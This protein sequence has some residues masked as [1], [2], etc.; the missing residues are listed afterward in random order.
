LPSG[1]LFEIGL[2]HDFVVEA[3]SMNCGIS[4]SGLNAQS[5]CLYFSSNN[6]VQVGGLSSGSSN[7]PP[8]NINLTVILNISKY[9]GN[10]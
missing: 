10:Y 6:T 5:L 1:G 3:G 8:S 9:V 7:I 4:G 2:P